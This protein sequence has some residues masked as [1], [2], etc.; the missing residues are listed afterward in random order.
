M[1][2]M[3]NNHGSFQRQTDSSSA[4][5]ILGNETR[6]AVLSVL[7]G[8]DD[9]PSR[10][11]TFSALQEAVGEQTS[12]G[13]AYHLRKL[14]DHYIKE[15]TDGYRLTYA[16][17]RVARAVVAGTYTESIGI[18]SIETDDPCPVCN[19]STLAA[20][21][22]D[23]VLVVECDCLDRPIAALELPPGSHRRIGDDL[24]RIANRHHR[25]QVALMA[26]GI[27]PECAGAIEATLGHV[28]ALEPT[29]EP[30]NSES[31]GSESTN[32]MQVQLR[33]DC[34][35]C[36]RQLRSPVTFAVVEHPAIVSF[37]GE[38]GTNIRERP[39]WNLGE[40]WSETVLSTEPWC[41]RVSVQMHDDR[42]DILVGE[43]MS[44]HVLD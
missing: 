31:S 40:E 28:P 11:L 26:D 44:T 22:I 13:F 10:T 7:L 25:Y 39:L 38:H 21:C 15:T 9:D 20:R 32:D 14:T 3:D 36:G 6:M 1:D 12:A 4:F 43:G 24:L 37:C 18:D 2:D 33:F 41:V 30:V 23:N 42:L 16:G 5:E 34:D 17:R 19:D 27:C 8:D 29:N 35:D